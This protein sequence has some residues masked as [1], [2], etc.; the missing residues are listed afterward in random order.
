ME[1]E[2]YTPN[3]EHK[4]RLGPYPGT[5]VS[6]RV[7]ILLEPFDIQTLNSYA[8]LIWVR[9]HSSKRST[10]SNARKH[11]ENATFRSFCTQWVRNMMT[12]IGRY[13]WR[14]ACLEFCGADKIERRA[15]GAG[16]HTRPI[17]QPYQA[18]ASRTWAISC[19]TDLSPRSPQYKASMRL[20]ASIL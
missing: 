14:S 10:L 5:P 15:G 16:S 8:R 1:A 12:V 3:A 13:S 6:A 19:K 9:T 4:G 2:L 7:G 11:G 17:S 20:S 18:R